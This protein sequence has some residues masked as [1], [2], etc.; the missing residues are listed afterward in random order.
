[1]PTAFCK[2]K[3]GHMFSEDFS[4][5]SNAAANKSN[6]LAKNPIGYFL[7]SMLAGMFIG[8]GVLLAFTAGGLLSGAPSTKV[9]MGVSFGV[10]L[11][12]VVMCGAELFT[13]NNLVMAAGIMDKKVKISEAIKLWVI[14]WLGNAAGSILL[15]LIYHLT[16]LGD[17]SVGEFMANAALGKMS[18]G[19]V[20]LFARG[21]LCNMLVCLAVWSTFRLKTEAGKLI[22]IFWCL[23]A[24]ITTGFE[25]SIANM[26]LLTVGLL[27]PCGVALTVGGWFY[28]LIIVTLGNMVGGICLVAFPY[29]IGQKK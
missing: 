12:L 29:F 3:G 4:A 15:A 19:G 2:N 7:L 14:C 26:T 20:A 10:A 16:A 8:F 1:M 28:N 5:V 17:G 13:G 27:R 11:S 9:V 24:F 6:Y 25:H 22:M 18:A 23:F 21:M